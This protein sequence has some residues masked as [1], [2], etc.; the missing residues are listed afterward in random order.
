MPILPLVN[1]SD[2]LAKAAYEACCN[3]GRQNL[4]D[5]IVYVDRSGNPKSAASLR[6][7]LDKYN[8]ENPGK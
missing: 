3:G 5:T 7:G 4:L 8:A 6:R 2:A 1:G